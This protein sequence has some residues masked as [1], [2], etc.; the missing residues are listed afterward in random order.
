M[1]VKRDLALRTKFANI[2]RGEDKDYSIRLKPLLKHEA[3]IEEVLYHYEF[4]RM[5]TETQKQG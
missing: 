2:S 4:N 5:T 3:I 1:V